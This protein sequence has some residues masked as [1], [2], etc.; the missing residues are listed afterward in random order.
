MTF[1]L[2]SMALVTVRQIGE[3]IGCSRGTAWRWSRRGRFREPVNPL[4]GSWKFEDDEMLVF[5]LALCKAK[6]PVCVWRLQA[7]RLYHQRRLGRFVS[8]ELETDPED[9]E[10]ASLLLGIA[11]RQ[12]ERRAAGVDSPATKSAEVVGRQMLSKNKAGDPLMGERMRGTAARLAAMAGKGN[13]ATLTRARS[14][15]PSYAYG[16]RGR[17]VNPCR[18]RR[19]RQLAR[20]LFRRLAFAAEVSLALRACHSS[21]TRS[22]H[23]YCHRIPLPHPPYQE[24]PD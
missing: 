16:F 10:M 6:E 5:N 17:A 23:P 8:G 11:S 9:L 4:S 13:D 20:F 24:P 19:V 7:G 12:F 15:V 14:P 21:R 22:D 1:N 18:M 2:E 3:R